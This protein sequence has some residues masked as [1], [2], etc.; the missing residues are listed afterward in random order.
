LRTVLRR[1]PVALGLLA[2]MILGYEVIGLTRD[3][4]AATELRTP[5]DDAIP[6]W[7]WSVY[8]Y[9][10]AYTSMLYPAFVVR[11]PG[12]FGR[13]AAAYG[14]VL[15]VSLACFALYPVTSLHLRPALDAL[16]LA[17]FDGWAVRFTYFVD[18]AYN[19]FPS[20]HLSIATLAML[21]AWT[22]R[23]A[24]GVFAVPMVASIAISICTMKQHFVVDGVVAL[25]LAFAAWA[26]IV[27]PF[28]RGLARGQDAEVAYA[29][30]GPL[31]YLAFHVAFYGVFYVAYRLGFQPWTM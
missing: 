13:V 15:A 24:F 9:S 26:L 4:G 18:P 28:G 27:R 2:A 8:L 14:A 20:L 12:L 25:P 3:P 19:L 7:P 21:S 17:T 30:G 5:L 22:A 16:D 31:A 29:W 11:S 6:F 1:T 10:W 23:R